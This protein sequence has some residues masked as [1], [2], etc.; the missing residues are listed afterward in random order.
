MLVLSYLGLLALIPLL[1]E[2]DDA[3]VQWHAKHGL[4]LMLASFAIWIAFIAFTVM[5]GWVDPTGCV[6]AIG[7]CFGPLILSV[8]ILA[9]H[10]FAIVKA[11][12][13]ERLRLPVVTDLVDKF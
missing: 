2:K 12:G 7:G 8:G 3:D 10:V 13:G 1:V 9:V 6:A 5:F 4:I 11:V